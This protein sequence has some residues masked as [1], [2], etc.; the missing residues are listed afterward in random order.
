MGGRQSQQI[1]V[2]KTD[3]LAAFVA[4][5]PTFEAIRQAHPS[6]KISL[7]TQ[8][9]LQRIARAAPYFDQVGSM[10]DFRDAEARTAFFKQ[11]RAARFA[12]VYDLS[13]GE[14]SRR[15]QGALG[16]FGPK[17]VSSSPPPRAVKADAKKRSE[18]ASGQPHAS[19]AVA[20]LAVADRAPDFHW[21]LA[22]RKDSANM[23]PSWFGVTGP[24][25]LLFPNADSGQRWPAA[26]YAALARMIAARGV[27]PVVIGSKETH[28]FADEIA[29]EAPEVVDLT[30]KTDH[31]QLASL[32]QEASFF[33]SDG[34][35]EIFLA[36]SVDCAGVLIR[37]AGAAAAV[38]PNRHIVTLTVK[39]DL[40]EAQPEFVLQ[41]LVNMG[42]APRGPAHQRV[43][44]R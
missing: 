30:G 39:S 34:A 36:A 21:A 43:G 20:G 25:G 6:A 8:A 10:P 22:S 44:A 14:D 19:L 11:V 16:P 2:I 17:W 32:A 18:R 9:Y 4:A 37:R 38:I 7:L 31:L 24:F 40:G 26:R 35:P 1:L 33:V 3:G 27:M 29:L 5:E 28:A 23:Q 12:K 41:A 13:L 42:V 15:L